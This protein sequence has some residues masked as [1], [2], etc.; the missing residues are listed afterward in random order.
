[1]VFADMLVPKATRDRNIAMIYTRQRRIPP[2]RV[3][4]FFVIALLFD[5]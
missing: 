1:M 5:S 2:P 3:T 4:V